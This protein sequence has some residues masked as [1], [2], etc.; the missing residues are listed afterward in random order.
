[1]LEIVGGHQLGE[2]FDGGSCANGIV[3]L[4]VSFNQDGQE[5]SVLFFGYGE[6]TATLEIVEHFGVVVILSFRFDGLRR[7]EAFD[8]VIFLEDRSH[9]EPPRQAVVDY[10]AASVAARSELR[11]VARVAGQA[12]P[13]KLGA[14]NYSARRASTG[15]TVAARRDGR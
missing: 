3:F 1:L 10:N 7:W 14:A 12:L 6:L 4:F 11:F 13:I 5:F 9:A 15:S 2:D 8:I